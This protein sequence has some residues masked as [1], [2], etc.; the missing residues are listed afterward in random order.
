MPR[1]QKWPELNPRQVVVGQEVVAVYCGRPIGVAGRRLPVLTVKSVGTKW[2][3]LSDRAK[4]DI[5]G[6]GCRGMVDAKTGLRLQI[7]ELGSLGAL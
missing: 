6:E 7:E 2:V 3:T 1:F 4:V 5:K